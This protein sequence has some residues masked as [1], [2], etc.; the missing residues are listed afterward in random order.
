M[1]AISQLLGEQTDKA[2]EIVAK[3][4]AEG[5]G[6]SS[7]KAEVKQVL[8]TVWALSRKYRNEEIAQKLKDFIDFKVTGE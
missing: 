2:F 6:K 3:T 5:G 1:K 7:A 8:C 4:Y